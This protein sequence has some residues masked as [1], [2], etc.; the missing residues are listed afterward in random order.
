MQDKFVS[1][2][3]WTQHEHK[4][5][6]KKSTT[7]LTVN[8]TG[9]QPVS[10]VSHI[11]PKYIYIKPCHIQLNT[12][13]NISWQCSVKIKFFSMSTTGPQ[14]KCNCKGHL[15]TTN[16]AEHNNIGCNEQDYSWLLVLKLNGDITTVAL[17]C[18]HLHDDHP[19]QACTVAVCKR[20][21]Q[22]S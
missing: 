17:L 10:A 5:R 19:L 14:T 1:H 21:N 4:I 3:R 15:R 2:V 11:Q 13:W 22:E 8:Y 6:N 12:N 18:S 20:A 9:L 16:A 7:S